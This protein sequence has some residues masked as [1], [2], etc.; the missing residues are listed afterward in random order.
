MN[1]WRRCLLQAYYYATW[2]WRR[3]L[4]RRHSQASRAPVII[5]F[6]HRVAETVPNEWTIHP[7]E[8][9]RHIR[10]LKSH[11]ELISLSEAQ[12]RI[13][14]RE[15][16]KPAV[17]ITFDD[18]YAD[19]CSYALPYLVMERI[20]FAYFVTT[21]NVLR[22]VPF[23]HDVKAGSPLRPNG[24]D[25]LRAL[26]EAG[27]EIGCHSRSH[28]SL[29]TVSEP[30]RLHDEVVRSRDELQQA[31]GAPVRYFAFPYGLHQH[32]NVRAF[33]LARSAGYAG[34]CSAYGGFNFP[35][36]DAFHLQRIHA[37]GEFIRLKNWLTMD[38]RKLLVPRFDYHSAPVRIPAFD[39]PASADIVCGS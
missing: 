4:E 21:D 38:P 22:G 6:Y 25:E 30:K 23:P 33:H 12:R 14:T 39:L 20:P 27:V 19:N 18:G 5:L 16:R 31:L 11:Y 37:D 26:A 24:L 32:L 17:C 29:G 34:V 3:L 9:T 8:F 36:D 7:R 28:V 15:N 10:W 13:E 35:G 1:P 2:H